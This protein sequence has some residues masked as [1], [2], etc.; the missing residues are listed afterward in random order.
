VDRI[1]GASWPAEDRI[2]VLENEGFDLRW[3]SASGA[4]ADSTVRLATQFGS[5]DVLPGGEWAV[6]QLSSGQLALLS[7]TG[8]TELAITRR[9]VLPLDSVRQAD[10][11]FG[12][13]PRWL[14]PGYLV[15]GAGDGVLTAMPFDGANRR[16]M[17]EPVPL[18]TGIR[19]EAGFGSAQFAISRD[20]TLVY[21]AGRNQLY[22]NIAFVSPNG[23]I[24][25][26]PLPRGPYTQPRLSPDGTLLAVQAKNP[27]GGWEVLLMNLGTGVRQRIEVEGSY[28]AFPASWLPSGRE[29]MVGL[30]DPVQF[31]NYGARI[32]SLDTG[33][34]TDIH[35]NGA[36][37][38]SIAPDGRSFVFS[39]WRTGDLYIRSLGSDTT[40]I[41]IPSRGFAASYS[42]DG[43]WVA[44]GG[45]DG[46]VAVSPVPPTGAIYP[47]AERGEMPLW[48]PT[49][50][51]L[52]F[53]DGSRYFRA[54][55]STAGGF[56][57]GR[58]ELLVE[59]PFLSTFAW[60][61][62]IA[63]DGRLLV[64]LTGPERQASTLGVITGF[65]DTIE[66][67]AQARPNDR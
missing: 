15:Y 48:T 22:V 7:L 13:S 43:D 67:F 26:L 64:L 11:L 32:Q 59:G 31:L 46:S 41:R 29:I 65:L 58:P 37:Y 8:G 63:P 25:T 28:R 55:I 3:I 30:W 62:D 47:V 9:G 6:G 33:E 40:R 12:T 35:L 16:V 27:V 49:G 34:W 23:A 57:A 44:W 17:G 14:R 1:T 56:R 50:D 19:M 21:V 60:N 36:S 4:R 45:V 42:P 52:V 51:G 53:R 2:L 24:D 54:P 38:M 20:G 61:H 66:R 39:D 5:P 10:L 18:I